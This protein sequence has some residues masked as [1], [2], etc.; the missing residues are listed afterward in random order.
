MRKLAWAC[1]A[2]AAGVFLAVLLV[3]QTFCLWLAGGFAVLGALPGG[4]RP[5]RMRL[6]CW[7]MALGMLVCAV[8]ERFVL[9]PAERLAGETLTVNAQVLEYPEFYEDYARVT[10]RLSGPD[11]P[12]LHQP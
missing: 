2:F 12:R 3:P 8:Q 4:R 6:L 11:L 9:E 1:G 5:L 7:G 10:V